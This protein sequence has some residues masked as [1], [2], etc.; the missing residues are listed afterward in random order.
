MDAIMNLRSKWFFFDETRILTF[1]I[2]FS[3][4]TTGGAGLVDQYILATMTT[5]ILGNSIEQ[6]SI[7]IALMMLMMGVSGWVQEKTSDNN[8]VEKFLW[9]EVLIATLGA[10][11]PIA[12]YGAFGYMTD[13]F[14]LVQY[15][16]IISIGFLIGFEIPIVMRI[17]DTHGIKIKK[18]IKIVYAMDYIGAFVFAIIW[19]KFLLKNFPLTEISF[20][21]GGFNFL[22]AVLTVAYFMHQ[23]M[24]KSWKASVAILLMTS[25]ALAYGYTNNRNWNVMMEQKFYD[26]PIIHKETSR[27]QHIVMTE[28]KEMGDVRVFINGNNQFSSTDEKR[29]HDLLVHPTFAV[30]PRAVNVLVL[31][32][33]DGLA[34]REILK[35]PTVES[36]SLVDLDPAMV[37]F[38]STN[39]VMR[40][41]N[42]DS[43]ADARVLAR[44]TDAVTGLKTEGVYLETDELGPDGEYKVEHVADI[45]VYNV[46]ADKFV[47][48]LHGKKWDIVIIDFPDPSSVELTKL[49]S[50]EFFTK[51]QWHMNPGAVVSIQSTSPYYAKES[52]LTIG[53]TMNSAGLQTIPYRQDIPS[54]GEWGYYLAWNSD[55]SVDMMKSQI[56]AIEEFGVETDYITPEVL[57]AS[58]AFGKGELHSEDTCVNTL[59]YPCLLDQYVEDAWKSY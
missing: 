25:I 19:V 23:K 13:H 50:R 8:L 48:E 46:D 47:S 52:Y 38:A 59:M 20:I 42:N 24:L 2:G 34:L 37:K 53:R 12:I 45:S 26:D 14:L 1:L 32:G 54:F 5:Y 4:F 44:A 18:N 55:I 16:F 35:Y 22:V 31:G 11:A 58:L 36:V 27:Y 17:I 33:G 56:R 7:V 6:F 9:V 40:K 57:V 41:L 51:L 28:N 43:F 15:F 49:Y 21:V 10:Y 39:E 3:M 29:Y 30:N